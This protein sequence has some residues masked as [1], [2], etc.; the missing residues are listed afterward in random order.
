MHLQGPF[1]PRTKIHYLY[2]ALKHV[3]GYS[4]A[5]PQYTQDSWIL[6]L[7]AHSVETPY[8]IFGHLQAEFRDA[9]RPSVRECSAACACDNVHM[10]GGFPCDSGEDLPDH[11]L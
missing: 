7:H 10:L 4:V 5:R 6:S 8:W 11:S 3:A 2:E 1:R 9:E